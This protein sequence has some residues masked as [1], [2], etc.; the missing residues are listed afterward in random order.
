VKSNVQ[1]GTVVNISKTGLLLS[2][3]KALE[4]EKVY[5]LWL[6][7]PSDY[8]KTEHIRFEAKCVWLKQFNNHEQTHCGMLLMNLNAK[9]ILFFE[10]LVNY[11][12]IRYNLPKDI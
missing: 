6:E 12:S 1:I 10:E 5:Q 11:I 8:T 7:V 3:R 4:E 9:S 2:C